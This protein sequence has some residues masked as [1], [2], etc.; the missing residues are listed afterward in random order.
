MITPSTRGRIVHTLL[1]GQNWRGSRK[2]VQMVFTLGPRNRKERVQFW[3]NFP[4][5]HQVDGRA[6]TVFDAIETIEL[7]LRKWTIQQNR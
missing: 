6:G 7:E 4:D 5:G 3:V 2:G 1:A